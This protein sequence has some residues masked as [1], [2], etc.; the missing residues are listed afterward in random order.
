MSVIRSRLRRG[1]PERSVG[2]IRGRLQHPLARPAR[3]G[4]VRSQHVLELDDVRRGL[5]PAE[6]ELVH[7]LDVLQDSRE[8]AR[9]PL[10]LI[11]AQRQPRQPRDV[12]NLLAIDHQVSLCGDFVV[13][14]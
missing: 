3:A 5:H 7:P 6:V 1:N 10:D 13:A 12:Q 8:L 2:G 4:L 14:G 11:L 9:H